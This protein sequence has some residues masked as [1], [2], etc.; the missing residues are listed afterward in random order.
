[1]LKHYLVAS[2]EDKFSQEEDLLQY[3]IFYNRTLQI[4]IWQKRVIWQ[5]GYLNFKSSKID[6]I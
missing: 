6:L 3:P 2:P 5:K 4:V 1:M